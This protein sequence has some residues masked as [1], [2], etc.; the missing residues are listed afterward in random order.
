M[1]AP[2]GHDA[3]QQEFEMEMPGVFKNLNIGPRLLISFLLI[4]ILPLAATTYVT[5][6][7][8]ERYLRNNLMDDLLAVAE[9]KANQIETYILERKRNVSALARMPSIV[10]SMEKFDKA[11]KTGGRDS[12]EFKAIEKMVRPFLTSF[13]ETSGYYDLF[14]ISHSGDVVFTLNKEAD[15]GTNLETGIFRDS[16]LSKVFDRAKT[17]M[18][19]EISDL[20]YYAPSRGPAAFI[21]APVF[22]EGVITGVVAL[23]MSNK[24]LHEIVNDYTGLAETGE[25]VAALKVGREAVIM[26]PLRHD[27]EAAFKRSIPL[28]TKKFIPMQEAVQGKKGF[29]TCVDYRGEEALAV[30]EYLPSIRWGMVVK[31]DTAEAL[32]PI[33]RMRNTLSVLGVLI[34]FPVILIARF[35]AKSISG[36]IRNLTGTTE[37]IAQGDLSKRASVFSKDEIGQLSNSFNEMTAKLSDSYSDLKRSAEELARS[38]LKLAR[39]INEHERAEEALR[40]A[41]EQLVRREKLAVL[42]QL[43]GG[44]GHELRNPLGVIKNSAFFLNMVL[45]D[46]PEKVSEHLGIMDKQIGMAD[47]IITNLLDFARVKPAAL[48]TIPVGPLVDRAIAECAIPHVI[49]VNIDVSR[50]VGPVVVDPSQM[51]HVLLNLIR[52]AVQAM[53]EGGR[54]SITAR[55]GNGAVLLSVAD[56][57]CGIPTENREKIFEPLF[58]TK[59]KGTGLGMSVC[60]SLVEAN[61]GEISVESVVGEGATL[62][63]RLPSK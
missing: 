5:Y 3:V 35:V 25:T 53:P 7:I 16:E 4:S 54:L 26:T 1:S 31:V 28:G 59:A 37:L 2:A 51:H 18:E 19:T 50:T 52:N 43:A 42:G 55:T 36:P 58:T 34:L 38:N 9:N 47:E 41:Q 49:D 45:A 24:E 32:A 27:A 63:L 12:R 62:I 13:K 23:Q 60:R 11:F 40:E 20:E 10:D 39:E 15:F 21:A 56:T 6:R 17:L 14:L 48:E 46:A 44:V 33:T 30:W 8:S 57:G 29:G 22:R 61:H